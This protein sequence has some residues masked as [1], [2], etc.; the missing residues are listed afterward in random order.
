MQYDKLY[1][2]TLISMKTTQHSK[3][4]LTFYQNSSLCT[5]KISLNLIFN[6]ILVAN[7]NEHPPRKRT[8]CNHSKR[9]RRRTQIHTNTQKLPEAFSIGADNFLDT[10]PRKPQRCRRLIRSRR[11]GNQV[12]TNWS[13]RRQLIGHRTINSDRLPPTTAEEAFEGLNSWSVSR[14]ELS[15]SVEQE[16]GRICQSWLPPARGRIRI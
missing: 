9:A 15:S 13:T 4:L 1:N 8:R 11:L 6:E 7:N 16:L 10:R 5:S 3:Q 2:W 14:F 12:D